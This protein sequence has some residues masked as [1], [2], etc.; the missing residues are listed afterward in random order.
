MIERH[1]TPTYSESFAKF[2]S[3]TNEKEVLLEEILK[4][5]SSVGAKSV[6]DI[7]AGNGDL[8]IPISKSVADYTAIEYKSDY[9]EKFRKQNIK[10]IE[11]S[12]PCEVEGKF[13]FVLASH[14]MPWKDFKYE[15]FI[16]KAVDL[17]NPGGL[18][19]GITYDDEKGEWF[20]LLKNC[21][22]KIK[23]DQNH[24]IAKFD[25]YLKKFEGYRLEIVTAYMRTPNRADLIE[26]LAFV[27]SD[28]DQDMIDEFVKNEKVKSYLDSKFKSEQGYTFPFEHIFIEIR[29]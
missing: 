18:F 23:H 6:L 25:E 11:A 9:A 27:Y 10:V 17:L 29:K 22:L 28:G 5:I 20:D 1:N 7:G 8:A 24:R 3:C 12:F 21:E 13:D 2:L 19:L 15:P 16:E 14:S 4:R 26:A